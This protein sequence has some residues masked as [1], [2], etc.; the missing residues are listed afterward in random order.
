ML[1]AAALVK[2]ASQTLHYGDADRAIELALERI[3][4]ELLAHHAQKKRLG[5]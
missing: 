3:E 5:V 2:K 4:K 1:A